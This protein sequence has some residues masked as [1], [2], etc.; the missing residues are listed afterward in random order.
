MA[1]NTLVD[2][3]LPRSEK[4]GN[5]GVNDVSNCDRQASQ[6]RVQ[7]ERSVHHVSC[8]LCLKLN[9][10]LLHE[11]NVHLLGGQSARQVSSD[12]HIVVTN[13]TSDNVRRRDA[14]SA[15]CC[16]EP[17]RILHHQSIIPN[18]RRVGRCWVATFH[19]HSRLILCGQCLL[20][21]ANLSPSSSSS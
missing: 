1:L 21:M 3:F 16:N 12:K 9:V 11:T 13:D 14:F 6:T 10:L 5:E 8:Y 4:C 2:S 18:I 20:I 15:L 19:N 17:A 7:R